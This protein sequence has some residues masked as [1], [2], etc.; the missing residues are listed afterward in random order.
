MYFEVVLWKLRKNA[1]MTKMF[2]VTFFIK[3]FC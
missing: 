1:K 3:R 2:D